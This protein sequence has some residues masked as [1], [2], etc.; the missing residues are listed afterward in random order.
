MKIDLAPME[1]VVDSDVRALLTSVGGF[2][3]CVTEFVRVVDR[4]LPERVFLRLCPE[5]ARGG[6]TPAGTPV[7]VQLLGG[8]AQ[9][10]AE[11]AARAAELGAPGIDI[12]FGCPSRFV[13]RK[14]GGAVLL[15][16]PERIERIVAATRAAL[17]AAVPLSAKVRLGYDDPGAALE[18][19]QAVEAGGAAWIVVHA[20]TRADG[21]RPPARWEALAPLVEA[22]S[23]PVVAN[24]DIDSPEAWA[25]CRALSGCEA[26]MVG[27]GALA[28]PDL[29]LALRDPARPPMGWP[30]ARALL[31]RLGRMMEGRATPRQTLGRLKQWLGWLRRGFPEAE[32]LF[33]RARRAPDP[34]AFWAIVDPRAGGE[35][36][37]REEQTWPM[38][39]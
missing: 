3:H 28:R 35:I 25:R 31:L 8:D 39:S 23:I 17:P 33:E 37:A 24:G 12:N 34:A 16:E 5:L 32:P 36:S 9:V 19:A 7:I 10:V 18:I 38:Q 27:R 21:Y 13:N 15:R 11:N 1:G 26:A 20:R 30:E 29:A 4:L 6:R 14:A 22:L 2:D